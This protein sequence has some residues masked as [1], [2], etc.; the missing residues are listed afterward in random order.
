MRVNQLPPASPGCLTDSSMVCGLEDFCC[1]FCRAFCI[2]ANIFWCCSCPIGKT[3][4]GV[5]IVI[6][7]HDLSQQING[8]WLWNC[9]TSGFN[10]LEVGGTANFR[11]IQPAIDWHFEQQFPT[12]KQDTADP[13]VPIAEIYRTTISDYLSKI[14]HSQ[15]QGLPDLPSSSDMSCVCWRVFAHID[16]LAFASSPQLP[17][18][19]NGWW[20][21]RSWWRFYLNI[22]V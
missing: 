8:E 21:L 2:S 12:L 5:I 4:G 17:G 13:S 22:C 14:T 3:I 18:N 19:P 20:V 6:S 10:P 11:Q 15:W 9:E 1:V 7:S 16:T